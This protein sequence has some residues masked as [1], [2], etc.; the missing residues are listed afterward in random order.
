[1]SLEVCPTYLRL[2]VW[3][4]ISYMPLFFKLFCGGSFSLVILAMVLVG[5]NDICHCVFLN[6]LVIF[7][8]ARLKYVKVAHLCDVCCVWSLFW[9]ENM[10]V[11][12]VYHSLCIT[13]VICYLFDDV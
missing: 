11:Q 10:F 5:Q 6:M 12:L 7:L 1:M 9:F 3:H 13:I 4:N 2:H 8:I